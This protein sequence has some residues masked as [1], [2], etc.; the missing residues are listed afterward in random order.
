MPKAIFYLLKG[1]YMHGLEL[2]GLVMDSRQ[3]DMLL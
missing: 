1:D 3:T 2:A